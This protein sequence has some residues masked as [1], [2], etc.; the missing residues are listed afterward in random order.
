MKNLFCFANILL[1]FFGVYSQAQTCQNSVLLSKNAYKILNFQND[2]HIP[3]KKGDY[4]LASPFGD[5]SE[6]K[7]AKKFNIVELGNVENQD[8]TYDLLNKKG[9]LHVK[10]PI[11]YDWMPALY[12]YTEGKN[13]KFVDWLYKNRNIATLNPEGPF[14]HCRKNHYTWCQD[15]YYNFA[16]EEVMQK[17][18]KDLLTNMKLRGFRGLFFD[19]AS[20]SYIEEKEYSPMLQNFKKFHTKQNYFDFVSKFYQK[21]KDSNIFVVTNQGFRKAEYILPFVTYDMTES[22]ITTDVRK[23]IK[24]Q[25]TQK[26][27]VDSVMVTNYY[28][29]YE[30]SKELKDSLK[31]I[32]LLSQYKKKYKKFG[33]K[34]FIYLNYLAPEYKKVYESSLLYKMVKPKNGIYFS[35]AMAK[36]AD[37]MVYAEVSKNR[38]LERDDIYFYDLGDA[39]GKKYEKLDA[40]NG[41]VRFYEKGFVLVSG[42]YTKELYLKI[43]SKYLKKNK[44]IYDTYNKI[45]LPSP[46]QNVIIDLKFQKDSFTKQY[47]PLGRVYLYI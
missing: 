41:Y 43:N 17:R 13:R 45:Y 1:L 38:K 4:T 12:Y 33:F 10:Y 8:V 47:L 11:G 14:V 5:A 22:Y 44:K 27:W 40:V 37:C 25:L 32:D 36:L 3:K 39:L 28:P 42:A 29:I 2:M 18:V 9:L 15:Y 7:W 24:V 20:G 16:N 31:F 30:D 6:I 35:Y 34:N 26:G 21:L 19:W 46:Q 23:K